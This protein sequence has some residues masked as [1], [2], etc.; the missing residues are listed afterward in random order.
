MAIEDVSWAIDEVAEIADA[1]EEIISQNE[2]ATRYSCIDPIIC[3]MGWDLT[4][5]DEV[6]VEYTIGLL[7]LQRQLA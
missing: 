4:D 3:A 5:P 1:H 7:V 2:T 6:R